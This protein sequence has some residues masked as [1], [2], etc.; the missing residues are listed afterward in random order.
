MGADQG[1]GQPQVRARHAGQEMVL[2]L[3]VEAA[4]EEVGERIAAHIAGGE[5]L[6]AQV[7]PAGALLGHRHALVVRCER[8]AQVQP[9]QGVV[10]QR[11]DDRLA[12]R[13][14]A[15]QQGRVAREVREKQ[16]ALDQPV[17]P[18]HAPQV[19][20]AGHLQRQPLQQ[21]H[22]EEQPRLVLRQ[23]AGE[24]L[25]FDRLRPRP[26]QGADLHVRVLAD[27]VGVR[28]VAVVLVGPPAGAHAQQQVPVEE[29]EGPV[30]PAPGR[31]LLVPRV[32]ADEAGAR[33]Q[34]RRGQRERQ[35]PPRTRAADQRDSRP[36]GRHGEQVHRER[37]RVVPPP[38]PQ[39]PRVPDLPQQRRELTA[40]RPRAVPAVP[41]PWALTAGRAGRT[42]DGGRDDECA[43]GRRHE[44]SSEGGNGPGTQGPEDGERP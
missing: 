17:P 18:R 35:H 16:P 9:E 39:Q 26:H 20:E 38:A 3:V 37:H 19:L 44:R 34:H 22:R 13:K 4:E 14:G 41:A 31:Y 8:T 43:A 24:T 7:A 23:E 2:D 25:P 21:Q 11:E 27:V 29:R 30:R 6:A 12:E 33:R 32:V 1:L 36:H 28:V 15:E 5:H 10:Q 40:R 42:R